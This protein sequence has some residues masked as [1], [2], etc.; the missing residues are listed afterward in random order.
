LIFAFMEKSSNSPL[1]AVRGL[2]VAFG[3]LRAVDGL[4][5]DIEAGHVHALIGPNGSGKSTFLNA[6]TGLVRARGEILFEGRD[7]LGRQPHQIF[8]AGIARTFQTSRLFP[9]L[10]VAENVLVGLHLDCSRSSRAEIESRAA[11]RLEQ[12]GL[13]NKGHFQV[14]Q[15][16]AAERRHL[17][18]AR[19][20]AHQPR[21]LLL[22]EP[23]AGM[24]AAER[25]V[26]VA[27]MRAIREAGTTIL[28]IE[29]DLKMVTGVADRVTALNFGRKIAEGAPADVASHPAVV[30]A[31]L[32]KSLGFAESSSKFNV[33]SSK[34]ER[35]ERDD[36]PQP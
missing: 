25:G 26:L 23:A 5:L 12:V 4:D 32:G 8:A 9:S 36:D 21:L 34:S 7:V 19:A 33:Q 11:S 27:L 35:T 28:L 29:H 13:A 22:D 30:E 31:Y 20:V 24:S 2:S 6:V 15:L 17:E 10:T 18:I 3:G 14:A 1:L 16:T